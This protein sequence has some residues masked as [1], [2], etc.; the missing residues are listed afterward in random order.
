MELEESP[1][2]NI[3]RIWD[4]SK[5]AWHAY[6]TSDAVKIEA[7]AKLIEQWNTATRQRI[8][9]TL[10]AREKEGLRRTIDHKA[11]ALKR[12]TSMIASPPAA[13]RS[14]PNDFLFL[15][16]Q[17][18]PEDRFWFE[19]LLREGFGSP[20]G[21]SV[22]AESHFELG[23]NV[24]S[25]GDHFLA[26]W[27]RKEKATPFD[28]QRLDQ[29]NEPY[30]LARLH[31]AVK[32]PVPIIKASHLRIRLIPESH[33]QAPAELE[34]LL[35][36]PNFRATNSIDQITF[37]FRTVTPGQ[38]FI[39]AVWDKRPPFTDQEKAGPGDYESA[40]LGPIKLSAGQSFTNLV[41]S[42]TNQVPGGH[43]YYGA[44]AARNA[45]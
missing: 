19:K 29:G 15:A 44:D 34:C 30:L 17:R 8:V 6:R 43:P 5:D 14:Q 20:I 41:L 33:P 4:H 22:I 42:C 1:Q 10:H 31:G 23:D 27:D 13:L 16:V 18:N 12:V 39:K 24:R 35:R 9:A 21:A 2:E 36:A 3:L 11:P 37:A 40:L 32:L 28:P 38:Y 45:R 25:A 7:D 26:I